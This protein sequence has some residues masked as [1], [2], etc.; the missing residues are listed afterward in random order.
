MK[1]DNDANKPLVAGDITV[2]STVAF[3]RVQGA[4]T[5]V[6]GWDTPFYIGDV[7]SIEL[8]PEPASSSGSS[9]PRPARAITR[10]RVHHRMPRFG[11]GH[12]D[13]VNRP[14]ALVCNGGASHPWT[15]ASERRTNLCVPA[16]LKGKQDAAKSTDLVDPC[17]IFETGP[18]PHSR[19]CAEE[20]GKGATRRAR[21]TW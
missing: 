1:R 14:W 7:L 13:D 10:V 18:R 12:D 15:A 17:A 11:S 9:S 16:E 20:S 2:G 5:G 6:P 8:E 21:A 4:P 3:K 19:R